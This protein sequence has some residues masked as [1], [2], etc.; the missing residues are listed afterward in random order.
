ML[1]VDT[2]LS[3]DPIS[4]AKEGNLKQMG[5]NMLF[6]FIAARKSEDSMKYK[7]SESAFC[8]IKE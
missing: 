4:S 3:A 5:E 7:K 6:Y 8:L 2:K 1:Y